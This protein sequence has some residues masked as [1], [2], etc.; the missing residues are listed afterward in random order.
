MRYTYP[1]KNTCSSRISFDIENNIVSNISFSGGCE[2][3]LKALSKVLDGSGAD[4]LIADLKGI[5][6][7]RRQTSCSDQLAKAVE[8]ALIEATRGK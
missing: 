5:V 3:N 8:Q 4:K 1:T 2:G 7:G 6:C